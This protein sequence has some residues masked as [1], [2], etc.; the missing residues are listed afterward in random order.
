MENRS[1]ENGVKFTARGNRFLRNVIAWNKEGALFIPEDS[2]E[3]S[4][5]NVFV[6]Q[7]R[8]NMFSIEFPS[9]VRPSKQGLME[10]NQHSG[11]DHRSWSWDVP[12]N[13][14]W[15]AMLQSRSSDLRMPAQWLRQVRQMPPIQSST[16][17]QE[18]RTLK[19]RVP[20]DDAGPDWVR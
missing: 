3:R 8:H 10:W 19:L 16:L 18:H 7:G 5:Q 20:I 14:D 4:N 11:Q 12:M 6:G 2:G 17:G 15:Q 1:D 9:M 13:A